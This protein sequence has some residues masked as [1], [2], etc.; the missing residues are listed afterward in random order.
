MAGVTD[1]EGMIWQSC[2]YNY[3]KSS[4]LNYVDPSG[5]YAMS[6]SNNQTSPYASGKRKGGLF[7]K[8]ETYNCFDIIFDSFFNKE[9]WEY[10]SFLYSIH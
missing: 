6:D 10:W 8:S 2:R 4:P 5:H 9:F 7:E 3:V 1:A